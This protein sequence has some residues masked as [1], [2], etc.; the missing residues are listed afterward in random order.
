MLQDYD[1]TV[2]DHDE[3]GK[4]TN[5]EVVHVRA[6][7]LEEAERK[8]L[9]VRA[10][11]ADRKAVVSEM[12]DLARGK[13]WRI[14]PRLP[15]L[16]SR[17][18]KPFQLTRQWLTELRDTADNKSQ[19]LGSSEISSHYTSDQLSKF[20]SV[21]LMTMT[22]TASLVPV[23]VL[24]L[25][26]GLREISVDTSPLGYF[27]PYVGTGLFFIA[28]GVTRTLTTIRHQ[29]LMKRLK[30]TPAVGADQENTQAKTP[31]ASQEK[32]Q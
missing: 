29:K 24:I 18:Y 15:T 28:I 16:R 30:T 17:Y 14:L 7:S 5:T 21:A 4:A 27:N 20:Q 22:L 13:G 10:L 31:N 8:A 11:Q 19:G 12:R 23:G 32:G 1:V 3:S 2:V 9:S 26:I 6:S 25:A